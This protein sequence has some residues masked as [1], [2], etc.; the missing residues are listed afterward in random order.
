[1]TLATR[2]LN[3]LDFGSA[4]RIPPRGR[5]T[6][7]EDEVR[8]PVSAPAELEA[9]GGVIDLFE[10]E[11]QRDA[12]RNAREWA[13]SIVDPFRHLPEGWNSY[14]AMAVDPNAADLAEQLLAAMLL[15]PGLAR[16]QAAPSADGGVSIEWHRPN[17]DLVVSIGPG[18]EPPSA[19]FSDAGQ[20]WEIDDLRDVSDG[21]FDA[22][23]D[24]LTS[25]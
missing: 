6:I 5:V 17:L 20:E 25:R 19:Y 13:R 18:D 8:P 16:P 12:E 2:G 9:G 1:M 21:R 14:G 22:A 11:R 23:L 3:D 7:S 10:W 4:S 15:R 24:A